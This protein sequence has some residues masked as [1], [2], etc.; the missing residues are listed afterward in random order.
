[1]HPFSLTRHLYPKLLSCVFQGDPSIC[2]SPGCV[3][4]LSWPRWPFVSRSAGR[5]PFLAA[6]Q[7]VLGQRS[8]ANASFWNH[9]QLQPIPLQHTPGPRVQ[10]GF[11]LG[12][13]L[14]SSSSCTWGSGT[15]PTVLKIPPPHGLQIYRSHAK[16]CLIHSPSHP[17]KH[18]GRAWWFPIK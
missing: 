17:R 1:M 6:L 9:I 14:A 3:S 16:S 12:S 10:A 15:P 8:K 11:C 7:C 2:P 18:A 5:A 13:F 4:W